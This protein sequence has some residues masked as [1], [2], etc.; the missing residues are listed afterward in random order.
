MTEYHKIQSIFKRDPENNHK[1]FLMW[2]YSMPEF[3][4]LAN[5]IWQFTEKVDGTNIRVIY[6]PYPVIEDIT[7][8]GKTDQAQIPAT[9]YKALSEMFILDKFKKVFPFTDIDE[10]ELPMVTLYGEGYGSRIQKGGGNYRADQSFVLFDIKVGK[11]WLQRKDLED[12]AKQ[13]DIDIVPIIGEG[14]LFDMIEKCKS[15]FKSQWGDFIAEGIVAR[16]KVELFTRSGH[17]II[18]KVKYKDFQ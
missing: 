6:N 9:L 17:R 5:N 1:T 18:T 8:Q 16:P 4:Y 12:L 11:W 10:E 13:L 7:F 15:G 2:D 3:E 14:S